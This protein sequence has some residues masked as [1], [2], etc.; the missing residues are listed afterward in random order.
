VL[1]NITIKTQTNYY[2]SASGGDNLNDGLS[3][4]TA[5][6]TIDAAVAATDAGDIFI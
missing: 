6:A 2:V 4:V 1:V 5:K 3:V